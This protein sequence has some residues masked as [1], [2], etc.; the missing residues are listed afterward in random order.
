MIIMNAS[1][2]VHDVV[3]KGTFVDFAVWPR[4]APVA[5]VLV[6]TPLALVFCTTRVH[7][8]ALTLHEVIHELP[9][10]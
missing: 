8:A 5:V 9:F 10:K 2:T 6:P 7:K 1:I 4:V 3:D